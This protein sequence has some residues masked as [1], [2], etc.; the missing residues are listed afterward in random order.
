[1]LPFT[2]AWDLA[3]V[4][5]KGEGIN[6][7]VTSGCLLFTIRLRQL[8]LGAPAATPIPDQ[9]YDGRPRT[10]PTHTKAIVVTDVFRPEWVEYD[11][12]IWIV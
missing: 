2:K 3:V 11:N 9:D 12:R 4:L 7:V 10:P 5:I 1:M 6:V 8:L